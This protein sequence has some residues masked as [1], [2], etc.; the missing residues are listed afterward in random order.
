MK[1]RDS[2]VAAFSEMAPR[3][4]TLMN[5]E[6]NRFWG[7]SY[8]EFVNLLFKEIHIQSTDSILDVATGTFFIP[9]RLLTT[10]PKLKQIV[11]LDITLDM[12]LKGKQKIPPQFD[13]RRIEMICGTALGMPLAGASFNLVL[14]GLA[15]H[16]MDVRE[17]LKE[18]HRLLK[19]HG[20]LA[21]ADVGGAQSWKNPVVKFLIRVLAFVY[22]LFTEN[23]SRAWAEASA[24]SNIRT[25]QEWRTELQ[26]LKFHDIQVSE[27]Q[28]RKMWMPNPLIINAKK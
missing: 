12:L 19:P 23:K 15:T 26:E 16:H 11:G 8:A 13:K 21:I 3:Y 14:C 5:N 18:I 22:F 1:E 25:S 2:I 28:S 17:L 27:M 7:W 10:Y 6:L 9:I 24:L 20:R 4:E